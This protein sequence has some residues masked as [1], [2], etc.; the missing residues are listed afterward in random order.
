MTNNQ[1]PPNNPHCFLEPKHL[2]PLES[3]LLSEHHKNT[4]TTFTWKKKQT[5]KNNGKNPNPNQNRTKPEKAQACQD[6]RPIII[7]CCGR[8]EA[9]SC[10]TPGIKKYILILF[11]CILKETKV[12]TFSPH[13]RLLGLI[14]SLEAL[15]EPPSECALDHLNFK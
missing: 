2:H 8:S 9:A 5:N 1:D 11:L 6:T 7:S 12:P 14:L 13:L 4:E 3:P 15:N 10:P